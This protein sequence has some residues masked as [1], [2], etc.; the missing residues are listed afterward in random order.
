ML[1]LF[2]LSFLLLCVCVCVCVCLFVLFC[3]VWFRFVSFRFVCFV[4]FVGWLVGLLLLLL[5]L[6]AL[7]APVCCLALV[8]AACFALA[9]TSTRAWNLLVFV[10]DEV[11]KME[12]KH[13]EHVGT[14]CNSRINRPFLSSNI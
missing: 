12:E 5:F 9:S 7:A 11:P 8:F 14:Y 13:M 2:L 1:H 3:F 6:A 4:L 10:D